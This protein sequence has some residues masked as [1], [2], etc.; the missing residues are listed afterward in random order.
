MSK[1]PTEVPPQEVHEERVLKTDCELLYS[2]LK[3][4]VLPGME[5]FRVLKERVKGMLA[6]YKDAL[7]LE[8]KRMARLCERY[9]LT[10]AGVERL[11]HSCT[12]ESLYDT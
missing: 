3:S 10:C 1:R 6:E 8:I 2:Q 11:K 4:A 5:V 9:I 7:R 12:N